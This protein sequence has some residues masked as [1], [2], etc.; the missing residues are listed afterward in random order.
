MDV[1]REIVFPAEP[2]E[3]W[4]ALTVPERLEDWFATEVELEPR[5]GGSGVFRWGNGEERHASIEE[6][7]PERL[8]T[9]RWEDG[10]G[11]V[12]FTLE[13]VPEGTRLVVVESS[14]EW[15]T[16]LELRALATASSVNVS[17]LLVREH[18]AVQVR[19]ERSYQPIRARLRTPQRAA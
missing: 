19:R 3:V 5:P 18:Q 16:A 12:V 11:E 14:P 13:P 9:L 15:S 2:A 7:D 4:E 8:L 17:A 6:V 1:R 10:G